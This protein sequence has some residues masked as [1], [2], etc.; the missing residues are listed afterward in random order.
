MKTV[1]ISFFRFEGLF[2]RLWA[3]SQMQFARGPLKRMPGIGFFKL[4]GT[5]TGEGFTPVPNFGVYAILATWPTEDA[6]RAA[7]AE[8]RVFQAWRR[9]A[10]EMAT[11]YL[12]A[13][14]SRGT[15]D[16]VAPFEVTKAAGLPVPIAVMTRATLKKR[17]VFDFWRQTPDISTTVRGQTNLKFKIGMGEVPWFQQVTFSIWDDPE[18]MKAFAYKS[19]SHA[20]AVKLVR[21]NKWFKEELY[22]RFHVLGFDGTWEGKRPLDSLRLGLPSAEPAP[23]PPAP[24]LA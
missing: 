4:F 21:D 8:G 17:Y 10:S 6:A 12:T 1:S 9:H 19:A 14:S 18:Q 23:T 16:G 11:V 20:G 3:F 2:N 13:L 15:W 5:G 24:A 22:A 7:V